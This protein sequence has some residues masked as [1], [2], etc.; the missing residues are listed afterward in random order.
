VQLWCWI[1][2]QWDFLRVAT[3]YGIVW[4][5]IFFAFCIYCLAFT[6]IW[7]HR[8]DLS[9][10]FNPFNE[11]PFVGTITTDI[12]IV[13]TSRKELSE[14]KSHQEEPETDVPPIPGTEG[15]TTREF[16]P[17]TVDVE[18][19]NDVPDETH[20]LP[21]TR[22]EI[23]RVG[24]ITRN[25]ALQET[26]PDAWLYARVAFLFFCALLLSWVPSSINR[27]YSL[28]HPNTLN[29]GANYV[30]ALVLPLQGFWNACVYIITSQTAC[31]NLYRAVVGKQELPRKSDYWGDLDAA[32]GGGGVGMTSLA[33]GDV[34]AGG[35]VGGKLD[36]FKSRRTSQK[37]RDP[38]DVTSVTSLTAAHR[39]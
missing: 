36:R 13:R 21:S 29:F 16:D 8:H 33:K 5:A 3:L 17:Y 9:G 1:D 35:G 19:G 27:V 11:D 7:R 31:R 2:T 37:L 20:R 38:S 28:A 30:E 23:F 18:V 14:V 34:G 26:N 22:P 10:L 39:R 4:V 24:S 6:K 15:E 12:E 32:G 25:A